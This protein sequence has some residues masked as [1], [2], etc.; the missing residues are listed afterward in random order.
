MSNRTL[1]LLSTVVAG[2]FVL[3]CLI[4]LIITQNNGANFIYDA[5]NNLSAGFY[6]LMI[7]MLLM[8]LGAIFTALSYIKSNYSYLILGTIFYIISSL[9]ILIYTMNLSTLAPNF[10]IFTLYSAIPI[11]INVINMFFINRYRKK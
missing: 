11:L 8:I 7:F 6:F 9:P 4:A 10:Y 2:F 5:N 3:F 1:T